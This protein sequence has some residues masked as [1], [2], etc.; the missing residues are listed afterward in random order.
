MDIVAH[1]LWGHAVLRWR[2]VR[3]ARWGLLAGALPDLIF[4]VPMQLEAWIDRGP[5]ALYL[6]HEPELWRAT[7]PALPE[8]LVDGY[9][10]YYVY[11]H[12]L[13]CLA[14]ATSLLVLTRWRHWAWGAVPYALHIV[15]DIP[16]HERFQTVPLYPLADWSMQGIAWDDPRLLIA[17]WAILLPIL[18]W[19][20]WKGGR[21]AQDR[22][23]S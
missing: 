6:K 8:T 23:N 12:S 1:A 19:Q 22:S 9:A 20:R 2:G 16:T 4:W 15:M 21:A 5:Q 13:L 10:H 18:V 7:G 17:N 3:S 14:A 11:S